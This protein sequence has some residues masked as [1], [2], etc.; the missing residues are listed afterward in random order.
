MTQAQAVAEAGE[1]FL[2]DTG[3]AL[4]S[5]LT[6]PLGG[7]CP[8]R[9]S[10][11]CMHVPA[12]GCPRPR[13]SGHASVSVSRKL[14]LVLG[15]KRWQGSR[16]TP[17]LSRC[18]GPGPLS[19]CVCGGEGPHTPEACTSTWGLTAA[20]DTADAGKALTAKAPFS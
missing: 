14:T 1:G 4:R 7:G 5:R 20:P 12:W 8:H 16:G 2:V 17:L 19:G 15:I 3:E 9:A 18:P 13:A 6:A 11:G 10:V